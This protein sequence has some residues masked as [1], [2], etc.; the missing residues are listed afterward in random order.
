MLGTT[1]KSAATF[2]A[3]YR[4]PA[5]DGEAARAGPPL[6]PPWCFAASAG[7]VAVGEEF[8]VG[9]GE[10]VHVRDTWRHGL[11]STVAGV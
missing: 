2:K 6:F 1:C 4:T 11:R 8:G 7:G 5:K 9:R 3:A 10:G